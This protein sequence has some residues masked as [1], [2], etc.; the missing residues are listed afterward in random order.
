MGAVMFRLIPKEQ[1]FFDLFEEAARNVHAGANALVALLEN[2]GDLAA[3]AARIKEIEHAGDKLTHATIDK[4]NRTFITPIDRED[5]HRL[6]SRLDDVLDSIDTAVGRMTLYKIE[7]PTEDVKAMAGVLVQATAILVDL[8]T[9]LRTIRKPAEIQA[10]CI[11]VHTMENEGDRIGQHA[12]A[13]LFANHT[14]AAT[15]I[16]WKDIYEELEQATDRCEDVANTVEGIVLKN[17]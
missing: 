3:R 13:A 1:A 11:E 6:I 10:K 17:A 4:L 7:K 5:I 14:D 12:L 16:K 9:S 8:M 15:I 2:Y